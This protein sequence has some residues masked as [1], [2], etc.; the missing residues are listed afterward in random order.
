LQSYTAHG[1]GFSSTGGAK[2]QRERWGKKCSS[3]GRSKLQH[4]ALVQT[5]FI[6]FYAFN[7]IKY[8]NKSSTK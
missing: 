4:A 5:T 3:I 1:S 8:S 7:K 6:H 2:L